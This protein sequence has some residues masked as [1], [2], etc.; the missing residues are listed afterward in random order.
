LARE[1]FDGRRDRAKGFCFTLKN[2]KSG[3]VLSKHEQRLGERF[4]DHRVSFLKTHRKYTVL[5]DLLQETVL[6]DT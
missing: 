3:F 4:N 6:R 1:R 5:R 2:V